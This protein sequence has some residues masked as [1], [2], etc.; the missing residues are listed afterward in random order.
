MNT[1]GEAEGLFTFIL[2]AKRLP[3]TQKTSEDF[4]RLLDTYETM[5]TWRVRFPLFLFSE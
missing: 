3:E 5:Y 2:G 4:Q 1:Q